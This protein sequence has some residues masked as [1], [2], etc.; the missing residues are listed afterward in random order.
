MHNWEGRGGWTDERV[1]LLTKLWSE[2]FSASQ[3]AK[4]MGNCTRCA[5]I[6]KAARLRLPRRTPEARKKVFQE[7]MASRYG[8]GPRVRDVK[9]ARKAERL[10]AEEAG[11]RAPPVKR[12]PAAGAGV[13]FKSQKVA[14]G[15]APH[16]EKPA[17]PEARKTLAQLGSRECHWPVGKGPGLGNGEHQLFCAEVADAGEAYCPTHRKRAFQKTR[18]PEQKAADEARAA[19]MRAAKGHQRDRNTFGFSPPRGRAA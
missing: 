16:A 19:R 13:H 1:E 4:M 8:D 17:T 3:I 2:G 18:T 9:A 6:G 14:A 15:A 11:L 7:A 12:A 10:A 5:V